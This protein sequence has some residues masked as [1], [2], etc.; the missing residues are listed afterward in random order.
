MI[1]TSAPSFCF[2]RPTTSVVAALWRRRMLLAVTRNLTWL[3]W[4]TSSILTVGWSQTQLTHQSQI[5]EKKQVTHFAAFCGIYT[6][7]NVLCIFKNMLVHTSICHRHASMRLAMCLFSVY[8]NWMNSM[9]VKPFVYDLGSDLHSGLVIFQ[10]YDVIKKGAVSWD[11]VNQ[12]PFKLAGGGNMKKIGR[13]SMV[14]NS[15]ISLTPY[16]FITLRCK[17]Q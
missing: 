8:R 14:I 12:P 13:I 1:T 16:R 7:T 5:L 4:P 10:L 15:L 2:K 3:S 11:K 17:L 9:G 6:C